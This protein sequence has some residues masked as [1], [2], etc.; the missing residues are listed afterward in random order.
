MIVVELALEVCFDGSID[1][2]HCGWVD[3]HYIAVE[4]VDSAQGMGGYVMHDRWVV[5]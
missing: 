1:S 4:W 2:L 5:R 3:G